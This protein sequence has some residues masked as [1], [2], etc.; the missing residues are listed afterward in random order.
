MSHA[1]GA[2]PIQHHQPSSLHAAHQTGRR[3]YPDPEGMVE[4]SNV[5]VRDDDTAKRKVAPYSLLQKAY[6][7]CD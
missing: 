4:S 7:F 3:G 1:Y 2:I 5:R 6:L